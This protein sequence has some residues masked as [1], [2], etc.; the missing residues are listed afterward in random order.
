GLNGNAPE[1]AAGVEA[2]VKDGMDVI[3]LSLGEAE[4]EPSRDLVVAAINA[5]ADAGVVPVVAA[6]N[7]F[8]DFGRGSVDSPGSATKAITAAAV[9]KQLAIAGFSSSGPTPV[10]LQMKPDVAAPG[11]D[12]TSSVP[13]HEVTWASFSGTSIATPHAAGAAA[14]L[15]HRHPNCTVAPV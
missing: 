13:P 12:I 7:D 10:S 6:G 14:L 4:I 9:T 8:E 11:A 3:N 2:A 1:I 5:A 15:L